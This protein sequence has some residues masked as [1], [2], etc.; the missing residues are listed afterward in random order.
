MR[1]LKEGTVDIH[2]E[3]VVDVWM[4]YG[5]SNPRIHARH[6]KTTPITMRKLAWG[7]ALTI[8]ISKDMLTKRFSIML[9]IPGPT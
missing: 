1:F 8:T 5:K 4:A 6:W 3:N 9:Y 7:V 2:K